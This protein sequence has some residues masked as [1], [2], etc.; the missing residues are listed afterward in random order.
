MNNNEI[1]CKGMRW[2]HLVAVV[3]SYG[4]PSQGPHLVGQMS[5]R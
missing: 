2:I 5:D 1:K 4:H 3:G